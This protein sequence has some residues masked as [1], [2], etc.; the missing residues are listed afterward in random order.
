MW[1]EFQFLLILSHLGEGTIY[2]ENIIPMDSS[3]LDWVNEN[4]L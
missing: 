3:S 4:L 1:E 2:L